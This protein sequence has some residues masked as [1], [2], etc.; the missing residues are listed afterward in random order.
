M[1]SAPRFTV[2][3][4]ASVLL[5]A[6]GAGIAAAGQADGGLDRQPR[7]SSE[8]KID[9]RS[10]AATRGR[11]RQKAGR[12]SVEK[13]APAAAAP[14]NGSSGSRP[15]SPGASSG[16]AS[17]VGQANASPVASAPPLSGLSHDA[18]EAAPS[19]GVIGGGGSSSGSP[20]ATPEPSTLLLMG[21]GLAGLYRLRRQR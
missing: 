5:L 2:G 12:A 9:L 1:G 17:P 6:G 20:S 13:Q 8:A 14:S 7:V 18:P 19:V 4:A 11:D 16:A 3:L 10:A 21:A 15:S